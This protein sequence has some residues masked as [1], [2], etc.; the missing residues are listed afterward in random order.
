MEAVES[1][2][3]A[4]RFLLALP[5]LVELVIFGAGVA[6]LY[7]A[8]RPR[9]AWVFTGLVVANEVLLHVLEQ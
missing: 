1:A 7:A 5:V 3:R 8:G 2:N 9:L 4:L 6:A